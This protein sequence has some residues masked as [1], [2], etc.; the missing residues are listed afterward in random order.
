M[1]KGGREGTFMFPQNDSEREERAWTH[2][3]GDGEAQVAYVPVKEAT[4]G[5]CARGM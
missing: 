4:R 3:C 5:V 2:C 1:P